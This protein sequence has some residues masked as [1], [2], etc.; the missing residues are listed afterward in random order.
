[1]DFKPSTH[2]DIFKY[3][4]SSVDVE[5]IADNPPERVVMYSYSKSK[6]WGKRYEK[7]I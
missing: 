4:K 3:R 5:I 7:K 1:M 6:Q 2:P